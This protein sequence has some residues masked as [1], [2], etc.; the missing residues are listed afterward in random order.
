MDETPASNMVKVSACEA[1]ASVASIEPQEELAR[2]MVENAEALGSVGSINVLKDGLT[3]ALLHGEGC[4]CI[5]FT[6]ITSPFHCRLIQVIKAKRDQG[7]ADNWLILKAQVT[8]LMMERIM[9]AWQYCFD[10]KKNR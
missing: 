6:R 8:K 5:D 7:K 1:R 4:L 9:N 3:D 10:G 2:F